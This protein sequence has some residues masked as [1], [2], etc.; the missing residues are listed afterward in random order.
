MMRALTSRIWEK[1]GNSLGA[2]HTG[3]EETCG[4]VWKCGHKSPHDAC[5]DVQYGQEPRDSH[6]P[7][8]LTCPTLLT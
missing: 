2:G 4:Q 1:G 8:F 3:R 7:P 6:L 5:A